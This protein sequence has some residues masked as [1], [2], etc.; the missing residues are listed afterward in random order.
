MLKKVFL[1][2]IDSYKSLS[3][4]GKTVVW[5]VIIKFIVFFG[6]LR[7]FFFKDYLKTNYKTEEKIQEVV[8]ENLTKT[9]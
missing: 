9:K 5:I 2:Y 3:K 8:R 4:L 1:F 6:V 7:P